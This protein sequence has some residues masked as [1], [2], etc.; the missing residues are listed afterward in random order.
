MIA[1]VLYCAKFGCATTGLGAALIAGGVSYDTLLVDS[2][3]DRKFVP[4]MSSLFKG[5]FGE[6]P[7]NRIVTAIENVGSTIETPISKESVT[8]MINK[9]QKMTSTEKQEFLNELNNQ[10]EVER[11]SRN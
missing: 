7:N 10:Y 5:V 11:K 8:E 6:G 4:F 2:G 3:Y 9:Y 1:K